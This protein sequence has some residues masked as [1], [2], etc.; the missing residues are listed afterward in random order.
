MRKTA[1]SAIQRRSLALMLILLLL[2]LTLSTAL[3]SGKP[4][5]SSSALHP[6][7]SALARTHPNQRVP[8]IVMKA[9]PE[10]DG[11]AV[12]R[13]AGGAMGENFA[14]IQSFS[15]TLPA[16]VL[17]VLAA[18]P[19]VR[20]IAPDAPMVATAIS[21][22][23]LQTVYPFASGAVEQWN[24]GTGLTGKGVTVAVVDSGIAD[25]PD[26]KSRII[27]Q[28][29][30]NAKSANDAI[31]HGT[32]VA[33]IIAGRSN[34]DKY[35]GIAPDASL[36]AVKATT[37]KYNVSESVVVKS[38]Q[39]VY[40]N[41]E[42]HNIRVVNISITSA[43]PNPY[44]FS[45]VAAAVE[46]LW[47][48]GIVV[49]VSAGNRG[50]AR[51]A[52]WYPPAND[53]FV[54]TVGALDDNETITSDDDSLATF[55]SRGKTQ[56]NIPK[57]ELIAPGRR[58][59]STLASDGS[60]VA[61]TFPDRIIKDGN[62]GYIRLSGTSMAAPVVT[63]L[64]ALMLE[65]YPDLTPDQVKWALMA[66]AESYSGQPT[67]TAGKTNIAGALDL[68]A[69]HKAGGLPLGEANQGA[70]WSPQ[71][72]LLDNNSNWQMTDWATAGYWDAAYWDAG[73]WDA[74]Y[75]DAGYWDAAYW[76]AGYWDAAY[77]DAAYWDAAYWDAAYW[78]AAYWD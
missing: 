76:D 55:S 27:A 30:A 71:V 68:I 62:R 8:V 65:R 53:P 19:G 1:A 2:S 46:K 58:I 23:R 38:L 36:V 57:P 32:H 69:A 42:R 50:D 59:V 45:P 22:K 52:V 31:G 17:P 63:G 20:Y 10:V 13:A 73:Y 67:G 51:D 70:L 24:A 72:R 34:Q 54:I 21:T 15:M 37:D 35:I 56:N 28:W 12:A 44:L 18:T 6:V 26:L 60:L 77:W 39:W 16:R 78:D 25:H 40:D 3:A 61:K 7:L 29:V 47:E 48:S 33:G 49:V 74:G 41:R 14:F 75:W 11:R 9:K 4:E 64:V 43:M 5:A 66:T